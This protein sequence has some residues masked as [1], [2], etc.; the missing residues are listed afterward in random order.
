MPAAGKTK[1]A[2]A[3]LLKHQTPPSQQDIFPSSEHL[4]Y[5][6]GLGFSAAV[7]TLLSNDKGNPRSR[8]RDY[9]EVHLIQ[10]NSRNPSIYLRAGDLQSI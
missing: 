10:K 7:I 3:L 2:K 9:S 4:L 1:N 6:R 5:L 8:I